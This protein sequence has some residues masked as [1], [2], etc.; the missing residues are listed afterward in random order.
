MPVSPLEIACV[1]KGGMY[2]CLEV[3]MWSSC[4]DVEGGLG[5]EHDG[6]ERQHF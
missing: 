6:D 5:Q 3:A 4:E 1:S 2:V